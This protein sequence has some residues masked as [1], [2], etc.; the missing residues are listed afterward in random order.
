MAYELSMMQ[1]VSHEEYERRMDMCAERGYVFSTPDIFLAFHD[2]TYNEQ[3]A[4][5]VLSAVGVNNEK[6]LQRFMK[7][8]P[9]PKPWVLWSRNNEQ[10]IRAFAWDRLAKKAGI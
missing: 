1:G 7:Y 2:E 5:F 8:A 9:H 6:V 4:Y 3:P 10:R